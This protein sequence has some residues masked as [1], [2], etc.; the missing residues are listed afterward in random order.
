MNRNYSPKKFLRLT[1]NTILKEYFNGKELLSDIDFD[2]LKETQIE[3]ISEALDGLPEDQKKQ[4]EAEFRLINEMACASGVQVLAEEAESPFH[5]LAVSE[6]FTHMKNHYDRVFWV[7]LHHR[8]VFD[9]ACELA[10]MDRIGGW[11]RRY[12]GENFTP[13][14]EKEDL[15]RLGKSV[16]A[17]YEKQGRGHHCKIDNYLRDN[18]KR[19]CYFAYPE[20]YATTEIG[21]DEG[22]QFSHWQM[23]RAFEIIF[24]YRPESGFLE[25]CARGKREEINELQAIFVQ[26]ILG[27]DG[28][29]DTKGKHFVLS[30]LMYKDF[31]FVTEPQDGVE[32]VIIKMLRLDLPGMGNRRITFEASPGSDGQP[33]HTLIEQALNKVNIP[34]DRTFV[35]KAR[36]QFLFYPRDGKKGK[37][38]T[39]EISTPDRSTLKDDPLD[40]IAKKYIEKWGLVSG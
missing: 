20:D 30:K 22:G 29:P 38:L 8:T 39:F 36:L 27:L 15:E 5:R 7:F 18:P 28:L 13:A 25:I 33:I 17:F 23:K 26:D 4:I 31:N 6:K 35:A 14:V 1:P 24:V 10:Y 19:H 3:P 2:S 16:S 11:N 40:Q 9:I 37:T 12:V 21:Y 34:L 32:K